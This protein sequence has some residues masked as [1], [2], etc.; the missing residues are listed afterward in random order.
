MRMTRCV[1][2]GTGDENQWYRRVCRVSVAAERAFHLE[3]RARHLCLQGRSKGFS[4]SLRDPASWP[5]PMLSP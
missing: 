1:L 5:E 3:R 2:M 4:R